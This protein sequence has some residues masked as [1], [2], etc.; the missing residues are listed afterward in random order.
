MDTLVVYYSRAGENYMNGQLRELEK[1]N[2]EVVAEFVAR[3]TGAPLF[4]LEQEK[5]YPSNYNAC[6]DIAL[7][8]KKRGA[9]PALKALPDLGGVQSVYLGYP[10][11]WGTVPMAVRTFLE[12][13]DWTGKSI[14]PFCT[15]EGSGMGVSERDIRSSA[16]N[17]VVEKGLSIHG[18]EA[19]ASEEIVKRWIGK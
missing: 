3:L 6:I 1:G 8:D 17:A 2:T 12:A 18:T 14:R 5:P 4:K 13:Y 11:Y 19:A 10:N 16:P 9:R 15:N 7:Q